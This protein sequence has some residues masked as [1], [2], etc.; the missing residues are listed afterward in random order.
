MPAPT[1]ATPAAGWPTQCAVCRAWGRAR[2]CT[3]CT[4]R[5]AA[6]RPRCTGCGLVVPAGVARCGAC[7]AQPLPFAFCVAALDYAFPWSGL[8]GALKFRGQTGV[9]APL[10]DLLAERV[11]GAGRTREVALVLP[12]PLGH[13]R[14]AERG[15]NQSSLLARRVARALALPI[16]SLLLQ[17]VVETPHLADLP[18][19]ERARAIRGA[20]ALAPGARPRIEG[21]ALALVDDV[22][23]TGATAAEAARTLLGAGAA[24]VELWVVART[25]APMDR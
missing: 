6:A 18:Q 22:M 24:S 19:P 21:R 23:T 9:V 17:R 16:G 1:A 3:D 2:V 14:L 13:E 10:A 15:F 5:H 20:F 8:V 12:V 25:P 11:R 4:A 7:I